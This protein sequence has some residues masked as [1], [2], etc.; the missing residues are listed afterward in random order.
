M[1]MREIPYGRQSISE[2]D[3]QA[4][5]EVLKSDFITRGSTKELLETTIASYCGTKYAI[6]MANGNDPIKTMHSSNK[7]R[8]HLE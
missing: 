2:E 8:S 6:I 1:I 7:R 4:V 5:V 3:I